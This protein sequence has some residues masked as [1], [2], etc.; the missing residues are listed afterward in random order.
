MAS[1]SAGSWQG[2]VADVFF[3][4]HTFELQALP[5]G[6]TRFTDTERWSGTMAAPVVAEHHAALEEEYARSAGAL[7]KRA[8]LEAV[9]PR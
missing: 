1:R 9:S 8:E 6:G 4:R 3:G 2:G 7:K 5:G